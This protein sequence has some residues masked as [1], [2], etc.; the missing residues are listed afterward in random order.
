MREGWVCPA[1]RRGVSPDEKTCDHGGT[2]H[3]VP[4]A[5]GAH[6]DVPPIVPG[7]YTPAPLPTT[8]P[9][10]TSDPWLPGMT[11]ID[12]SVSEDA[13]RDIEEIQTEIALSTAVRARDLIV[14]AGAA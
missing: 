5:P 9:P 8:R 3:G 12:W 1:C 13:R 7:T 4:V 2:S 10:L 11:C 6:P 14:G